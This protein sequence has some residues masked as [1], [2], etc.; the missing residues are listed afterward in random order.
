M[1]KQFVHNKMQEKKYV[2]ILKYF[3]KTWKK[4]LGIY[5]IKEILILIN[6]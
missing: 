5:D 6:F 1:K 3:I 4:F 2:I